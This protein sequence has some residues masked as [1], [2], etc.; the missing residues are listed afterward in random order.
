[1][2]SLGAPELLVILLVA[3]LLLG[4][5]KLGAA[6]KRE[7]PSAPPSR[8][9]WGRRFVAG[10]AGA[11]VQ[12]GILAFNSPFLW[13]LERQQLWAVL[14][15]LAVESAV[16]WIFFYEILYRY[17]GHR[18]SLNL[19]GPILLV[20]TLKTP[21]FNVIGFLV[22]TASGGL[23][24]TVLDRYARPA[25][26]VGHMTGLPG[27]W[28][29]AASAA[30]L[31]LCSYWL[32]RGDLAQRES[33]AAAWSGYGGI[34]MNARTDHATR[35][36]CASAYVGGPGFCERIF[37]H[38]K[39]PTRAIAPEVGLDV[40]L[41]L[42]V[43]RAALRR[44][45]RYHLMFVTVAF[46][47]LIA[48]AA[49]ESVAV[50]AAG[51]LVLAA[52]F[53]VK[54]YNDRYTLAQQ[55]RQ[56]AFDAEKLRTQYPAPRDPEVDAAM[57]EP[58]QNLIVYGGFV[59]FVGAGIDLGGWSFSVATD[60]P[61]ESPGASGEP[62]EFR[63]PELYAAVRGALEGIGIEGLDVR[64]VCFV[65]G[66]DIRQD[67]EI[68]PDEMQRPLQRLTQQR[69][70]QYAEAS[71]S[72]VRHYQWIC[73]RDW[74]NDL[75]VSYYLRCAQ[76]GH[77]LFVEIKRFLLTP[78]ADSYRKVDSLSHADAH[79]VFALLVGS[80]FAGPFYPI[81]SA[82]MLFGRFS[83]WTNRL[84]DSEG[85]RRRRMIRNSPLYNYGTEST[86]RQ[87]LSSDRFVHYFQ[88]LDGDFYSKTL[89]STMLDGIVAFLDEHHIDTSAIRERQNVILNSGIIVQGGDVKAESLAVG[90]GAQAGTRAPRRATKL[91]RKGA[92]A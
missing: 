79:G 23:D 46:V 43:C 3:V 17:W 21:L 13:Q 67:R 63:T 80:L 89:E 12:T 83:E 36:L 61:S 4:S 81:Y 20:W 60:K 7:H 15:P 59:P 1:M 70:A 45:L 69:I 78:L 62:E 57:P 68:L 51:I 72:R 29:T 26:W 42:G 76:R 19:A 11:L 73:V 10:L 34:S 28:P 22:T 88:K 40:P 16:V 18:V 44:D 6:L 64:D 33:T 37:R 30:A 31:V 92:G 52:L 55:F 71:D 39:D 50:I 86:L 2:G 49:T 65:H 48:A 27:T 56:D 90:T 53:F 8:G 47:G 14:G 75:A 9:R 38:F 87:Q 74:G 25:A 32:S 54:A 58:D 77:S 85:R 84:F 91:L 82:I 66:S 41:L 5:G 24:S 35:F